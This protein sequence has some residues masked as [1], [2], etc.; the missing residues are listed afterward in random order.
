MFRSDTIESVLCGSLFPTESS[1]KERV[2]H[3]V[4]IFSGFDKVEVKALERILEQKQRYV[5]YMLAFDTWKFH[6]AFDRPSKLPV[7]VFD[8]LRIEFGAFPLGCRLQQEMQRYLSL[9]QMNQV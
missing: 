4:R 6:V 2:R 7:L 5:V 1:V 3:W 9:R 8:G